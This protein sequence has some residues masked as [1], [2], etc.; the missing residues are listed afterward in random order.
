MNKQVAIIGQSGTTGLQIYQRLSHRDDITVITIP[1]AMRKDDQAIY[2]A[3]EQA[4]L[5]FL[6]LPDDAAKHVVALTSDLHCKIIDTSTAHR[7]MSGWAYGFPE[8]GSSFKERIKTNQYIANP[9]CHASGVISIMAPLIQSGIV[10]ST[11]PLSVT[12]LTGYSGGG[13]SMIAD[14][15][16]ENKELP[17]FSPQSYA[18]GQ[19]H[20]HLPE[21]VTYTQLAEPPIF[22]PVVDDYYS[23]MLV[24]VGL[25]GHLLSNGSIASVHAALANTYGDGPV[26]QVAPLHSAGKMLA[27]NGL[28]GTDKMVLYVTG[29]DDRITV[30]AMYD[31]LGKG[32]SGAAVQCM[33]LALGLEETKGLIL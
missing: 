23:G 9:G 14:Y 26:I 11:Y 16:S 27:A 28:T 17:L 12:S 15:E 5:I 4:D 2:G 21:I 6:C 31:N 3:A 24:A 8:L 25:Q 10:P 22:L 33:N 1:E 29:N 30:Y 32:A 13:K 20:K 18:L 7:T 19:M